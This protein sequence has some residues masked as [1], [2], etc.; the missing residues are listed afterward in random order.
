[1]AIPVYVFTGFLEAGKTKFIQ[2][3]LE[4]ERF[5][6]GEKTL[7]LVCEE[8]EEEYDPASFSAPN[9]YIEIID[10]Q[11]ALTTAQLEALQKKHRA[12][13]VVAELNGMQLVSDF[14]AIM[15]EKWVVYQEV[16]VVDATTIESYNANM[17]SLV[18]DKLGGAELVI[19]N[20]V[21]VEMD[22]TPMHKLVRAIGGRRTEIIY[23][24]PDGSVMFDDIED[25]LPW[26]MNAPVVEIGDDD[27]ALFYRDVADDEDA[28]K[29]Y[30]GKVVRF[31]GQVANTRKKVKDTFVPGRFVMTC[32]EADI[33]FMG[34]PCEWAGAAALKTRDWVMVEAKITFRAHP[35]Y[36]NKMGPVL[37][38]TS[39][40]P[41]E[42]AEQDVCTF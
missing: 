30:S 9:V 3:T 36:K 29:K 41:A 15:P 42:A 40:E 20:R 16:C 10:D 19:F 6:A 7:L 26:D 31:R 25:P 17:R 32:C 35:L 27:Y 13:R 2:E 28:A 39:V 12:D 11:S 24:R 5:N 14:Y 38:A 18:V 33:T 34:I 23:E 1:M 37:V 4:D 21:P 22:V 8:G